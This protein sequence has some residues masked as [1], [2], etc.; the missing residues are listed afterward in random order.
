VAARTEGGKKAGDANAKKR[1]SCFLGG[2]EKSTT[3]G[4]NGHSSEKKGL[5]RK[6]EGI[7]AL[8]TKEITK[9]LAAR[10]RKGTN[11]FKELEKKSPKSDHRNGGKKKADGS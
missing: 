10:P 11:Y 1:R 8:S 5:E 4:E 2:G 7:A 6:E 3:R 9:T